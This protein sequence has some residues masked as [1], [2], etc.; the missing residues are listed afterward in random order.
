MG[1]KV[2]VFIQA[3]WIVQESSYTYRYIILGYLN[4][5]V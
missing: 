4:L 2:L 1:L 3:R 5:S